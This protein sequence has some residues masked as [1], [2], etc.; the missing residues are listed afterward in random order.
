MPRS[1]TSGG[2]KAPGL[3]EEDYTAIRLVPDADR[4]WWQHLSRGAKLKFAER[5][6]KKWTDDETLALILANP[7]KDDYYGLGAKLGRAP[8]A[9][10]TRR[11]YMIH[12][13]K[14][15]YGYKAK[16]DAYLADPKTFHKYADIGQVFR[17]MK[18]EGM[19][20][21][22]VSEQFEMARHLKQPKESWRGDNTSAV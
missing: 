6:G 1:R 5:H 20:D 12:L 15:E 21:L 22:P 18:V 8:G 17:L 9:V 16:A 10:R 7:D 14:G 3:L 13:L 19:L 4:E 2:P 11:A